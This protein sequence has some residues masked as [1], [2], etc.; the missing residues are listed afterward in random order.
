M[1]KY[2]LNRKHRCRPNSRVSL[3]LEPLEDRRLLSVDMSISNAQQEAILDGLTGLATWAHELESFDR[4]TQSLPLLRT[5]LGDALDSEEILTKGLRDPIATY[6]AGDN[7]PT[8]GELVGVLSGLSQSVGGLEIVVDPAIVS[9]GLYDD[10]GSSELRFDLVLNATRVI[11]APIDLGSSAA[12]LGLHAGDAT[13]PMAASL[14]LD[15]AFGCDLA[16][17]LAPAESFFIRIEEMSAGAQVEESDLDFDARVGFFQTV[18]QNATATL[19]SELAVSVSNPDND[20]LESV[21][22]AELQGTALVD[23]VGLEPSGTFIATLPVTAGRLGSYT[24]ASQSTVTLSS[25][26]VFG[27]ED[28]A[29]SCSADFGELRNFTNVSSVDINDVLD[30]MGSRLGDL[31]QSPLLDVPLPLA[32]NVRLGELWNL[33]TA[34]SSQLTSKLQTTSGEPTYSTAQELAAQ[35]AS[36]LG[37]SPSQVDAQYDPATKQL[38][39]HLLISHNFASVSALLNLATAPG[40]LTDLAAAG[41][42][43]DLNATAQIDLVV[44]IDLTSRAAVLT[45]TS[46]APANGVLSAPAHF[47]LAVGE[48]APTAVTVPADAS[49]T[50]VDDLVAD[51]NTALD[52]AGLN[53]VVVAG[54]DGDKLTLS[55]KG[56]GVAPDLMILAADGDPALSELR[57]QNGQSASYPLTQRAFIRDG[58]VEGTV[59]VAASDVSGTARLGFLDVAF[60]HGTVTGSTPVSFTLI[61]PDAATAGIIT[62][63]EF[64]QAVVTDVS[65]VMTAPALSGSAEVAL[66]NVSA[67]GGIIADQP[68]RAVQ[69]TVPFADPSSPSEPVYTD[70]GPL[71]AFEHM[72][73]VTVVDAFEQT[74]VWLDSLKGYAALGEKLP[75]VNRSVASLSGFAGDFEAKA[76][77][78]A[79]HSVGSVQEIQEQIETVFGVTPGSA[80]LQMVDNDLQFVLTI[81]TGVQD[82]GQC[83]TNLDVA[84]LSQLKGE[85]PAGWENIANLADTGPKAPL[86]VTAESSVQLILGI[87]LSDPAVP[88]AFLDDG[89]RLDLGVRAVGANRSFSAA[90]GPLDLSVVNGN[91]VLDADGD[92]GTTTPATFAVTLATAPGGRYDLAA[93]TADPASGIELAIAG[94]ATAVL[95]LAYPADEPLG[96]FTLDISDLCA[97]LEHDPGSVN[98]FA[99][100]DLSTELAG[101]D[102]LSNTGTVIDGLDKY[103]DSLQDAL[104]YEVYSVS[105]PF[106]GEQLQQAGEFIDGSAGFRSSLVAQ[107]HASLDGVEAKTPVL[108]QQALVAALG[109]AGKNYLVDRNGD[110]AINAGDIQVVST[111]TDGD[112]KADRLQFD[113]QLHRGVALA[114]SD[115]DFSTGLPNLDLVV[116]TKIRAG[117]G[118]D[119]ALSFGVDRTDGFYVDTNAANELAVNVSAA[120]PGE[121]QAGGKLGLLPLSVQD[122]PSHPSAFTGTFSVDVNDLGGS[123]GRLTF[124]E[125]ASMDYNSPPLVDARLTGDADINLKTRLN[126]GPSAMF[127]SLLADIHLDWSFADAATTLPA[128]QF[129]NQPQLGF[130]SVQLDVGSFLSDFLGPVLGT[131]QDVLTPVKPLLD[132]VTADI[133]VV[134]DIPGV[135]TLLNAD[136]KGGVSLVDLAMRFGTAEYQ[137]IAVLADVAHT[138]TELP[139]FSPGHNLQVPL[140]SFDLAG[141]ADPRA[142]DFRLSA[143]ARTNESTEQKVYDELRGLVGND[144]AQTAADFLELLGTQ[145]FGDL[146]SFPLLEDPSLAFDILLGADVDLFKFN[147]PALK[148]EFST[149][150]PLMW[151]GPVPVRMVGTLAVGVDMEFGYD[152]HGL[153]LLANSGDIEDLAAGFYFT[154]VKKAG[155]DVPEFTLMGSLEAKGGIDILIAS[156][157]VGGGIYATASADVRDWDGDGKAHFDELARFGPGCAFDLRGTMTAGL[158]AYVSVGIWPLRK[159]WDFTIAEATLL[160]FDN[161]SCKE[162]ILATDLG[163]GVLRLNMGPD[164]AARMP[165]GLTPEEQQRINTNGELGETFLVS[166]LSGDPNSPSGETVLVTAM[167]FEQKY[168]G[169]KKIVADGGGGDDSIVLNRTVVDDDGNVVVSPVLSA[170]EL[171]GGEGNDKLAAGNGPAILYGDDGNDELAG[172]SGNDQLFGGAGN[173]RVVGGEGNDLLDGG[174]DNDM[175]DG[176]AGNDTLHGAGGKDRLLGGANDDALYGGADDDELW[177]GDGQDTLSGG[178][179]KDFLAGGSGSDTLDGGDGDDELQGEEGNDQILGGAGSDRLDGGSGD[180]TLD[181]G[182]GNDTLYG[183]DAN[184]T[185][186]GGLGNDALYGGEGNDWLIGGASALVGADGNDILYGGRGDD[187]L[188]GGHGTV[189]DSVATLLGGEGDDYLYGGDGADTLYGQGGSDRLSGEKDNDQLYGGDGNDALYGHDGHDYIDAGDGND[190]AYGG[191]GN[192]EIH[193]GLGDDFLLGDADADTIYGDAGRDD[194]YGGIGGDQLYGGEDDDRVFGGDGN[195]TAFGDSGDDL[196]EGNAGDDTLWGGDGNDILIAGIGDD[197]VYGEVGCDVLYGGEGLD[198]LFGGDQAD[199]LYAGS[200]NDLVYGGSGDDLVF[201]EDGDDQLFGES[202]HDQLYGGLGVDQLDGGTGDD[203]LSADAGVGNVLIGGEG[204]D[205]IYGS[206]EGGFDPDFTDQVWFGDVIDAGDGNDS[207]WALGGSDYIVAGP[208]ADFIDGGAGAD[209]IRGG[210]GDDELWAGSGSGDELFGDAGDD[211]LYGSHQGNDRIHGG[212]GNDRLRG[213]GGNDELHGDEG[214]DE[215]DGGLGIDLLYGGAGY[216][217]L[218]GGGVGDMLDGGDGN[219]ILYGSD[220]GADVIFAGAG[221]DWL[222]GGGGNDSLD[223]GAGDDLLDGGAGDD[224][225]QGQAGSDLLIGGPDHDILYGFNAD[226]SGDD[227]AIDYLYGD[228]GSNGNQAGQGR[229]R[230]YG[231]GGNDQLFGEGDDDLLDGSS[232]SDDF[233]DYGSGE[234]AVPSD[235]VMPIPTPDPAIQPGQAFAYAMASLPIGTDERGRW[236]GFGG[237]A[238]PLGF[239]GDTGLSLEPSVVAAA[240]AQYV[241]WADSRNGNFEIYVARHGSIG[242]SEMVGSAQGGGVSRTSGS[243]RSPSIALDNLGRP[244][245]AWT[246][247]TAT[248]SNVKVAMFNP[249]AQGGDG[250]WVALGGSLGPGGVSNT[251]AADQAHLIGSSSGPVVAWLDRSAGWPQVMVARFD[252]AAWQSLGIPAANPEHTELSELAIAVDGTKIAVAWTQVV[253]GI[254]QIY[255][256]EYSGGQWNELSGSATGSGV[257]RTSGASRAPSVAYH[258]GELFVAWQDQT[259]DRWEIYAARHTVSGWEPAGAGATRGGGVSDSSGDATQPQ[260]ASGGTGLHLAWREDAGPH[261]ANQETAVYAK[262]WNGSRFAE[263]A[264]GDASGQGVVPSTREVQSLSLAVDPSGHPFAAWN[265]ILSGRSEVGLVGNRFEPASVY[266]AANV[267][268]MHV[269]VQSILDSEDLDESD[270]I[271]VLGVHTEGFT[272]TAADSGVMILGAP[273]ASI[274]GQV[275]VNGAAGVTLDQLVLTGGVSAVGSENLTIRECVLPTVGVTFD[276]GSGTQLAWNTISAATSVALTGGTDHVVLA[277]NILDGTG[278]GLAGV[279]VTG[280][281]A[282]HLTLTD[283]TIRGFATGIALGAPS[284]GTI[285]ANLL[286]N[287]G[288]GTGLSIAAA[289]AGSIHNNDISGFQTGVVYAAA[290]DLGGNRIH[291]N[292]VGVRATVT[293]S[294]SALGFVGASE[295]NEIYANTV[296]VDLAGQMQNQHIFGNVTG[297]SGNGTLGGSD[298]DHANWIERN[299]TPLAFSGP[300]LF[301]RIADNF[302]GIEARNGQWIA[303]NLIYD[304]EGF[305]LRVHGASDVCIIQNTFYS[306]GDNIRLEGGARAVELRGNILWTETG[307]DIYVANDSQY[308]FFSDYNDLHAGDTGKLVYWTRDFT[309]LLDWQEDVHQFDLHSIGRT[310][311]NPAWS[312]PRFLGRGTGDFRVFDLVAGRRFSSPTRDAADPLT[313]VALP[314]SYQNL[315]SNPGF[316][317]G[318]AGWQVNSGSSTRQSSPTPFEALNYFYPGAVSQ[319]YTQQTIDLAAMGYGDAELDSRDLVAVFGGRVRVA[320]ESPTDTGRITLSFLDSSGATISEKVVEAGSTQQRWELV[321]GRV[322]LPQGTR[323]LRFRYEATR[324]AGSENNANLDNAFVYLHPETLLPDLGAYGMTADEDLQQD[325]AHLALR[326]PDLYTDWE[327]DR[328]HTIRWDTCN[329]PD[330]LLIRIDLYQDGPDGPQFLANLAAATEDDGQFTW[331]PATAGLDYGTYGLRI[332]VSLAGNPAVFDRSTE[333]FTVP[334]NSAE[335]YVNDAD[336]TGDEYA[337]ATGSNRHTGRIPAAPKP[338]PGNVLRIYTLGPTRALFVDTGDYRLLHP[339]VVSG[340]GVRGDDEGFSATGPVGVD[341]H[342]IFRHANSLTVAPLVELDDADFVTLAHLDLLDAQMGVWVHNGSTNFAAADLVVADHDLDGI[343]VEGNSTVTRLDGITAV[344]NGR[345]GIYVDGRIEQ[346]TAGH[347]YY[348]SSTGICLVNPGSVQ[349]RQ[350]EVFANTGHGIQVSNTVGGTI[351]T[352][353]NYDLAAAVGNHVH[354]NAGHGVYASGSVSVAGNTVY[355]HTGTG[356]VGI[357]LA[358]G[359]AAR[360]NV[361]HGNRTGIYNTGSGEVAEN[362]AYQNADTGIFA[363]SAGP[364]RGNAVYSNLV[365]IDARGYS[366]GDVTNNLSYGNTTYGIRVNQGE[367]A[368]VNNTVYQTSG[369]AVRIDGASRNM[370][371]R[372]NVLMAA[373]GYDLWFATDSLLGLSSDYSVLWTTGS[374]QVAWWQNAPRATLAAWRSAAF[375]DAHSIAQDPLFV[376]PG[377]LD[378][379]LQSLQGSFHGGALAPVIDAGTGLPLLLS[380]TL[381]ADTATSPGVDRGAPGDSCANEPSPNGQF[382]N[383]GAFGNTAQ[384]SLSPAQYVM[385]LQP[386]GGEAWIADQTFAIQ[387]RSQDWQ[388]TAAVELLED[389]DGTLV[390]IATIAETTENDGEYQWTVPETVAA[391]EN[392]FVRVTRG[393]W[394]DVSNASFSISAPITLFYVNDAAMAEGD[395]TTAPG[396]DANDGLSPATPKASVRALLETYD[397]GPG[398]IIRVDAGEYLLA[399]NITISE[400]DSGVTIE[401]YHDEMYPDRVPILN[402]GNTASGNYVIQLTGA[403]EVTLEHLS[404]TGGYHGIYA[405]SSADSDYLT[406]EHCDIYGNHTSSGSGIQLDAGNDRAVI[407]ENRIHN[408][409]RGVRIDG[410]DA[411]ISGNR[412]YSNT[413][414]GAY[415]GGAI[416]VGGVRATVSGNEV[417]G[418][419]VGIC[420][421]YTGSWSHH[422]TL[423]ANS[424]HGNTSDGI[425][426]T[427]SVLVTGNTVYDNGSR[428]ILSNG[429]SPVIEENTIYDNPTGVYLGNAGSPRI[430]G[431]QIYDNATGI[432]TG[433]GQHSAV[434]EGNRVYHNTG[435]GIVA[436][437]AMTV[438]NNVVYSN[439]LGIEA[440]WDFGGQVA[441]NLVYANTNQGIRVVDARSG[442][443]IVNNTVYQSVGDALRIQ[444]SSQNVKVQNNVLWTG[445]GYCLSVAT[446]SQIGLTSDYNL[447]WT[448][449]MGQLALW[450]SLPFTTLADWRYEVAQDGHSLLADPQFVDP[451]GDDGL[452][453]HFGGLTAEYFNN[454]TLTGPPVLARVDARVNFDWGSGSP[455]AGVNADH[456]SVCWGGYFFVPQDGDYTLYTLTNEGE[457]LYLDGELVID[458]W[459]WDGGLENS[460]QA[461]GLAAGWHEIRYEIRE[462]TGQASAILRWEG[463]GISKQVIPISSF[464]LLPQAPDCG[465]DD[466]F[467]VQNTSLSVDAGNPTDFYLSEPAPNG[468]RVNLGH[469]G[470]TS[471]AT[472]SAG[473]MVQV[474]SPN[475]LEKL[476]IG[477]EVSIQWRSSGLTQEHKVA[478]VNVG[479]SLTD[480]WGGDAFYNGSYSYTKTSIST[481]VDTSGVANP[482]PQA[483]YQS[484]AYCSAGNGAPM[485]YWLPAADGEYTIRLHFVEPTDADTTSRKFDIKLQGTVVHPDYNIYA[486]AGAK[487]KATTLSFPVTAT[488]GNGISLDLIKKTTNNRAAILSGIE[489]TAVNPSGTASPTAGLEVSRD[490]GAT[491]EPLAA[492]RTMDRYGWGSYVWTIT[493]PEGNG[494]SALIRV[495]AEQGA[496]PTDTSDMGF[497][498]ANGGTDYYVNDATFGEGDWTTAAGDNAASGKD[499]AHPMASL[500]ALLAAYDLHPGDVIHVD[501]GTY[502][503]LRNIT[504]SSQDSGVTIEG[505]HDEMYPDRVSILNRGN[506][507]SGNYVI[508]L[509]GADDVTLEYLS[510]TNGYHGIYA[511]SSAD[512]DYLTVEHCDIYGNHTSSG[513]GIQLDAGNDRAVISENRIHNNNRGVRIDGADALISGN[514]LY[515]NTAAGAYGGGAIDVGGVRATVSGNEVYGNGVGICA[516]Y[517]G[518]WSDRITLIG[519]TV[520]GNSSYGIYCAS[521]VLVTGNTVYDNDGR[522]IHSNGGSPVIENNV[523]RGHSGSPA[524][525][526]GNG[527]SGR[528]AGNEIHDNATGITLNNNY[529][530]YFVVENNRVYHNTGTGIVANVGMTVRNNVVYSN[531]LGIDAIGSYSGAITNNLVY[532]NTNRGIRLSGARSGARVVN[533]TVYQTVGDAL[534]IEG[535]SQNVNLRNNILWVD[536]GY[537]LSVDANSQTGFSSDRNLFYHDASPSAHVGFWNSVIQHTLADWQDT[538][539]RDGNSVEGNPGFLDING[540]DN[541]L[542]YTTAADGYDGGPD[543]NFYTVGLS[544]AIDAGDT[545]VAQATDIRGLARLDDP[546]V[547]NTGTP[548]YMETGLG[549]SSF[550]LVGTAKSWWSSQGSWTLTFPSGFSFPFY[551]SNYTSVKVS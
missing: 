179:G 220:D 486:A 17:G 376:D 207:V 452:L 365:G 296:G 363:T 5:S 482:A 60:E 208:G 154:D 364:M 186:Y 211:R 290:A 55:T 522:G 551:G 139:S 68:G 301:N 198:H 384:A 245:V 174:E 359:A 230:L 466:D 61:D 458:E 280:S 313:D 433:G 83:G 374:G 58:L 344:H 93:L 1:G 305:N 548:D 141:G 20:P 421:E 84:R 462:G 337:T 59:S 79:K 378:F 269:T 533:N 439:S 456:F 356:D 163:G 478:L 282:A 287:P 315:L 412:L 246:E 50:S 243:S 176:G 521:S 222:L 112:E 543:D 284:G 500:F 111:D 69:Y 538:T 106:F 235:F 410:A 527:G 535:S 461:V 402:R 357:Y 437:Y 407:S 268:G 197:Y 308:G 526:L 362:R 292:A 390:V 310:V 306:G 349:L 97:F 408:N 273:G 322:T 512:S 485:S 110:H 450:G 25:T 477:Q 405:A 204:N 320:S 342:A 161:H 261:R 544:P 184:D 278:T 281:G 404:I 274:G 430:T 159:T 142:A 391:G 289:F 238:G 259:T 74:A 343:R 18:V 28:P 295:P 455:G 507:A 234:S 361:A 506:T 138:I 454:E 367:L 24:P 502:S 540:A 43:V 177:G 424:V 419:G 37:L 109:P 520:H 353:G 22:L 247:W 475:G 476:E 206:D 224:L 48:R 338:Y 263:N 152:S 202:G 6:F 67:P 187:I 336:V 240:D 146:L 102:L 375:T 413:A 209:Y 212:L 489:L 143:S 103:L 355:G 524:I 2:T 396:D 346:L 201:G 436:N 54:R 440:T 19:Q 75:I 21:T 366:T 304:N 11:A 459:A 449:G 516:E 347:V 107:L 388:D 385:L 41:G 70:M 360:R 531:S 190:N 203:L 33:S 237:S 435:T 494:N 91:M 542:G 479:G 250:Q 191:A 369:D 334:E 335:F 416:D 332:A 101:I 414:A 324:L 239:S 331:I 195:D 255:V 529:S 490:D 221:N 309:D 76:S 493:G 216:D 117:V 446:D 530:C 214:D 299:T 453:G 213:Q 16:K 415:G 95:P 125:L 386:D 394:S 509:T 528:V 550:A 525:Y 328:P 368:L 26:D 218:R 496:Q 311:L 438:R 442:A 426:V 497:L 515:S 387:W 137:A 276:G 379:H 113:L 392:Y 498:I 447:F 149:D 51:I 157:D 151:L 291:D 275:A 472:T 327:L 400:D 546:G 471:E 98:Q 448:T 82:V 210:D 480:L 12:G 339:L 46:A 116:N 147:P 399:A 393:A 134:S 231:G 272:I 85:T 251:G 29:I 165:G 254:E 321:G 155:Q 294:V 15:F 395:W 545:W 418:N 119:Y 249:A 468:G 27:G 372:N 45:A 323:T 13:V 441:N 330:E 140:G 175:L 188:L 371:L 158:H 38:T 77:E 65:T 189:I 354:D 293:G 52:Q 382:V 135:N 132:L 423:I 377:G 115:V 406:V 123:D 513:S 298:L 49:N 131:V 409:N 350:S 192:D 303:H 307:H 136:G 445:S 266:L 148:L 253:G 283:N 89:T 487:L 30:L 200:G 370:V 133:P 40:A 81:G 144:L 411:L 104:G 182:E 156:A 181:G 381:T 3:R 451:D 316:E 333:S 397:F 262:H 53:A 248:G 35:F 470:N 171:R 285:S 153:A 483:V 504:L 236:T 39:Y 108:V 428:G 467:R 488:G 541:V 23:L 460:Y 170:A 228:F 501:A 432:T 114:A 219:D 465:L 122:D 518:S 31:S 215:L 265:D 233:L 56:T 380:G 193:G 427:D 63:A 348:N 44:G 160:D 129:G 194:I 325:A 537:C 92:A 300:V 166:H 47:T 547:A 270:V 503:L 71:R 121:M 429:G 383:L 297:I 199:R 443:A 422:I 277:N 105:I 226:G 183:R 271:V 420:A 511:A 10:A 492:G 464:S 7:S 126:F 444:G 87:D 66:L 401:G 127:P 164:A 223:G 457:R 317:S 403:D 286:E 36:V 373:A 185:L 523:I 94:H 205:R 358:S 252:G 341:H 225:L 227:D 434:V 57:F 264:P 474:V 510:I 256:R 229:D 508:Q 312:E 128:A 318:L 80:T 319:G 431:N 232:G 389:Q 86:D 495:R 267:P 484:Y 536:A 288:S 532:A 180:D 463:P 100:P 4:F 302:A 64:G 145:S 167:G 217:V 96:N 329:N 279:A 88:A 244:V 120:F 72:S 260:M 505:Y 162:P 351:A 130:P 34:V 425:Y 173:D 352:I 178:D 491:W 499:P 14:H 242:W 326:F 258:T 539:T 519:N 169:V 168:S 32:K 549:S 172:G 8:T 78:L 9:G 118:F 314:A 473:Q 257:S 481:T 42:S 90:A 514:R 345:Y 62:L 241:A 99:A 469:T 124:C 196:L 417:Y 73:F 534:R 340:G 398:D 517:T 150:M